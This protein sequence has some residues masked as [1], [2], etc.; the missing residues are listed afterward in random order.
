PRCYTVQPISNDFCVLCGA[1]TKAWLLAEEEVPEGA[2]RDSYDERRTFKR[3]A[4]NSSVAELKA[5]LSSG[6]ARTAER[7]EFATLLLALRQAQQTR[8]R[9]V[10]VKTEPE[11]DK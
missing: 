6:W 3:M 4:A 5:A 7:E 11:F 2:G 10:E 8:P 9:Q 1:T